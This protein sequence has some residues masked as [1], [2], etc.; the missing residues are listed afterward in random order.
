MLAVRPASEGTSGYRDRRTREVTVAR[1]LF[2]STPASGHVRPGLPIAR[3]LTARGHDVVWYAGSR[4]KASIERTGARHV[5]FV[6]GRDFDET[7]LDGSFPGRATVRSGLPQLRFDMR[8]LFIDTVRGHLADLRALAEEEPFAVVVTESAFLAGGLLAEERRLP[9]AVYGVTPLTA[10]SADCAPMGLGLPPRSGPLGRLRNGALNVLVEKVIFAREQRRVQEIRTELGFPRSD[11]FF[12]DF[13]VA[14]APVYLQGTIPEF[15]YPR[16]DLPGNVHFIG[17]L[18]PDPPGG[19]ELPAW[20]EELSGDRPVVLVTQGTVEVDPALLIRPT[21]AAL[22]EEDVLLVGTTG[23]PAPEQ[24]APPPRPDNLR[25]ETFIPFADLLP[26]VDVVV[27]SGGYGGTQQALVHGVP[28]VVAGVTEGKN[29]V[30]A[31]VAWS[32]AGINLRTE[33][34]TPD[35]IRE[36]VRALLDVPTYRDRARDLQS[37]YAQHD[38]AGAAADLVEGLLPAAGAAGA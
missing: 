20:W 23:G 15:E 19:S 2:G 8:A 30:A 25:L 31:R 22:A 1:V 29:E 7:D 13:T 5:P 12:L 17:A 10:R 21:I 33:T 6:D 36:A 14:E 26:H 11:R 38:A 4:F 28:V 32:G 35:Q 18:L 3:E 34:P 9:W 24:V 37:R 27:T 16:R